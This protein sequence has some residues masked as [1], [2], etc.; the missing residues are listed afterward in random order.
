MKKEI[1]TVFENKFLRIDLY[2]N[3]LFRIAKYVN[4]IFIHIGRLTF[5]VGKIQE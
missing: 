2:N 5:T 1:M 4:V 3:C